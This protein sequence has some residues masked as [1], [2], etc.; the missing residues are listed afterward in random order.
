MIAKKHKSVRIRLSDAIYK[1]LLVVCDRT[2]EVPATVAR[3]A[4]MTYIVSFENGQVSREMVKITEQ[5]MAEI[6][7][8]MLE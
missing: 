2:G 7:K 8:K 3:I 5:K 4:L 6:A 1:R